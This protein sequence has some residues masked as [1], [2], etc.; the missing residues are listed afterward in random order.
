MLLGDEDVRHG[1]LVGDFLE[2]ILDSGAV[3]YYFLSSA[4]IFMLA[5]LKRK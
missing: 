1:T 2:R 4:F 3:V 5:D